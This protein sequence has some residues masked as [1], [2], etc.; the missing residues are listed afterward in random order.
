MPYFKPKTQLGVLSY[1]D[2]KKDPTLLYFKSLQKKLNFQLILLN[3]RRK[4]ALFKIDTLLFRAGTNA[5]P[6]EIIQ[7]IKL[8]HK[9]KCKVKID[10][11]RGL[12]LCNDKV[13]QF[14]LLSKYSI[15]MPKTWVIKK[16]GDFNKIKNQRYPLIL[17]SQFGFGGDTV[18]KADNKKQ[19]LEIINKILT[20][21]NVVIAQE[22]IKLEQP[23]D[24][25]VYI[26]GNKSP[27][28]VV[29]IAKKGDFRANLK[30]GAKKIFFKPTKKLVNLAQ[31]ICKIMN[32]DIATVDFIKC[33]NKYYFLEIN[34]SPGMKK[35]RKVAEKILLYCLGE[36]E[37][38]DNYEME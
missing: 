24:F 26:I 37:K 18:Y 1:D 11:L 19:A 22:F 20:N 16:I 8:Y 27:R 13:K 4:Y 29:R 15:L 14:Q 3:P 30:Q 2:P 21:D 5:S 9:I 32:M 12:K 6:D 31:K 10:S 17:K 33:K 35:D 36:I 38:K 25:R 23:K 34:D 28:G 7:A